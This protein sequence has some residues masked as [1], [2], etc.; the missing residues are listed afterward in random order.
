MCC[1]TI[2]VLIL[3]YMAAI[4]VSSYYYICVRILLDMCCSNI[5]V[6]ILLHMA[7]IYVSSYYYMCVAGAQG[8][9]EAPAYQQV[10]W[11]VCV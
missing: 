8:K 11:C 3:R 6:L 10:F 2:F 7:A 9:R 4:Y 5:C 1:S